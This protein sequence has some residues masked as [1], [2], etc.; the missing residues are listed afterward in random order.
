MRKS[1][2]T[3]TPKS[4]LNLQNLSYKNKNRAQKKFKRKSQSQSSN[5]NPNNR[6]LSKKMTRVVVVMLILWRRRMSWRIR[7]KIMISLRRSTIRR[8]RSNR[9]GASRKQMSSKI[10]WGKSLMLAL[11]RCYWVATSSISLVLRPSFLNWPKFKLRRIKWRRG[12]SRMQI[13]PVKFWI[14]TKIAWNNLTSRAFLTAKPKT[15]LTA[16]SCSLRH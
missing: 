12:P 10:C 16:I 1:R 9:L 15:Y 8:R 7:L 13:K 4:R 6:Y 2:I 14:L 11:S 5:K 3:S